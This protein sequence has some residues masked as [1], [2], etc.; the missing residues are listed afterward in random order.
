MIDQ[1]FLA[2]SPEEVGIDSDKLTELLDRVR[3]EVDEGLLPSVQVAIARNGKLAAFETY[4]DAPKDPLYCVFS[5]TKAITSAAAWLLIQE[6][7]LDVSETVAD[8][9][10]EFGAN[11]KEK[12]YV[13]QLFTHTS[14]FPHAP[15]RPEEWHDKASRLHRFSEWKLNWEPGSRFE[16]HPTSSMWMIAEIIERRSGQSFQSFIRERISE[17][18]GLDD[19]WVGA[20]ADQHHRIA[21]VTHVG[22]ALTAEDYAKLGLP[23][24]PVTEVTEEALTRFNLPEVRETPV[25]GGGGIMSAA[26]LALFYQALVNGGSNIDGE[27]VWKPETLE[28]AR[29]VRTGDL[30][31]LQGGHRVHR[32]LGICIAGDE[33][34]NLRGFGHTNSPLA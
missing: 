17:P 11:G 4:G 13:E 28:Y 21:D 18:L 31:D 23:V 12:I 24:P 8:I 9:V 7:K 34:R 3:K 14:G 5:S 15:F 20:P 27:Q 6:G 29:E 10:P 26:E 30:R 19:L 2:G 16:Y 33:K 25:A 32:A 22:D 1:R